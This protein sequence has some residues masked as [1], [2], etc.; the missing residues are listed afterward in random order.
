MTNWTHDKTDNYEAE[1]AERQ[2]VFAKIAPK[3]N[4]KER[5]DAWID[6]TDFDECNNAAI[7]FA[8]SPLEI[9]ARRS[10]KV[11]VQGGGY[12]AMVGA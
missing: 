5:I 2:A 3:H 11:R 4:W 10:T 9:V 6:A 8:A 12:Y 1:Q 7:W